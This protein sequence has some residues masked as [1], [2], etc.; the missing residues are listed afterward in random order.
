MNTQRQIDLNHSLNPQAPTMSVIRTDRVDMITALFNDRESAEQAFNSVTN[1]G[2]HSDEVNI[3]MSDATRQKHFAN[4]DHIETEMGNKATEGAGIG[5]AIGGTLGA[6][7]AV[8]A[9]VGTT[10]AVPGLGIIFY[11][12]AVAALAG[13]GAG[14]LTGGVVGALIGLGIS[15]ERVKHYQNG[16]D[17]GGILMGVKPKSDEDAAHIEQEWK[18]NNGQHV[19]R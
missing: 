1:R 16:I 14:G 4:S 15:E 13:L 9:T 2:Y 3:V 5:S 10:L 17:E 12:P 8:V 11:G 7:A 6:I 18:T 19:Y